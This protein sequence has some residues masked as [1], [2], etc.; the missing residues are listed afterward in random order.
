MILILIINMGYKCK[1]IIRLIGVEKKKASNKNA[2]S[3]NAKFLFKD[4]DHGMYRITL[5]D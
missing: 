1:E 4:N 5:I 2:L 3:I